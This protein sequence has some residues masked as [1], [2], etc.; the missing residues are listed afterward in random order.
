MDKLPSEL[1]LKIN[2]YEGTLHKFFKAYKRYY[3]LNNTNSYNE[4]YIYNSEDGY[5]NYTKECFCSFKKNKRCRCNIIYTDNETLDTIVSKSLKYSYFQ[6]KNK[7]YK[8][9]KFYKIKEWK[10][11]DMMNYIDA[12]YSQLKHNLVNKKL[13]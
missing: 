10:K 3:I 12:H 4:I 9:I 7:F 1:M 8:Y 2:C 11:Y 6:E 13:K 5:Y